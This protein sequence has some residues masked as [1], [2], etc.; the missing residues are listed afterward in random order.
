MKQQQEQQAQLN[1]ALADLEA[2]QTQVTQ[3]LHVAQ[4]K[5]AQTHA[6][7]QEATKKMIETFEDL[8]QAEFVCAICSELFVEVGI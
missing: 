4:D 6:E 5:A 3:D 1:K 2:K 7:K 8:V